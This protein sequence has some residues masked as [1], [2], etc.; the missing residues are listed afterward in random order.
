[1]HHRLHQIFFRITNRFRSEAAP[2]ALD[3]SAQ[4]M[5]EYALVAGM[6]GLGAILCLSGLTNSVGINFSAIG[7]ALTSAA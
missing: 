4:S 1:M 7:N 5:L 2:T 3:D 6:I